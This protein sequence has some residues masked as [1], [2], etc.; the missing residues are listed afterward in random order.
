MPKFQK[1]ST[2]SELPE[3]SAQCVEVDGKR[4]AVFN[5]G[6]EFYAIDDTCPHEEGPLSEGTVED[7]E[8]VCPWHQA[9]FNL[10]TGACTG[11]PSDEDVVT[12]PVRVNGDDI[13]LEV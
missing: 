6:G 7:E 3:G 5:V 12:Y 13:E 1:V 8:V 11:P 2:K 4:I 9:T 10:K